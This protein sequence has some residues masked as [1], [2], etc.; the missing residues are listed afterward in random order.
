MEGFDDLKREF[1]TSSTKKDIDR[2]I[3]RRP[4]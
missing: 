1:W 3:E 2:E 4:G